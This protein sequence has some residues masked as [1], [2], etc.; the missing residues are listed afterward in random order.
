[1]KTIINIV[2][3]FVFATFTLHSAEDLEQIRK[4]G[5][6]RHL[7]IPYAGF[8]T[9]A[10][11]GL[12]VDMMKLFA[13]HLGVKYKYIQT[14][15][16]DV[17]GDLTGKKVKPKGKNVEILGECEIKGDVIA[18]GFTILPWRQK[19]VDY[20]VATFPTQVW[21]VAPFTSKLT[22]IKPAED[23]SKDV[24]QTRKRIDGLV[25]LG[26][27]GTCLAPSLYNITQAGATAKDFEGGLNELAP[28]LLKGVADVLLL[29]VPDC[30]VALRKWP[31]KLKVIG[32]MSEQQ[33]MG[34]AFRK[35]S[36]NLRVAFNAFFEQCKKNGIYLCLIRK[37][38]P[39]VFTY[40]PE[41][42]AGCKVARH[43]KQKQK[44][45][46]ENRE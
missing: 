32:P 12:D 13:Q 26:K 19:V 20:S 35:D 29:D 15:W 2:F 27:N 7:S 34:A 33:Y 16:S 39:D 36:P 9:G 21:L 24:L 46:I 1:M 45:K 41:F 8:N 10:G 14:S 40:Y 23:E 17:I 42:F 3:F 43:G 28:A 31:G 44:M 38:Y 25:V 5:V 18:N 22:P 6:L 37:Y 4:S 11:D 30:L